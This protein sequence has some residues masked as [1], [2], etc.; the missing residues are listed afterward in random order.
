MLL[1][2]LLAPWAANAQQTAPYNEGFEAM[3][4]VTDLNTAGWEMLYK[5]HS[6][7]FL[8]IETGASNVFAGSKALNIDSWNAG[9]S[10]DWVIV[11]LPTISNKA[12]N[13]LQMTFSY[14]VSTGNV[15]IGYLTDPDD[16]STFVT[17][18]S[19]NSSSS[20]STKTVEFDGVPAT[21]TRIAIKY[22]NYYRCYVD[23][24]EVKQ[25]PN[26]KTPQNLTPSNL[27]ADRVTLTWERNAA[28]TE[29]AW[30][31]EYGTTSDF[32]GA[33]TVSVTGGNPTKT[34]TGLTENTKY[35]ARVKADCGGEES[36]P[37]AAISFTTLCEPTTIPTEGWS[38][39]FDSYTHTSNTT[40][41]NNL[42][43]CWSYI[44]TTTYSSYQGY[45][46]VYYG[47]SYSSSG[48]YHLRLYSYYS[49]WSDYDPQPQYAIL[50]PMDNLTGKQITLKA[51]GYNTSSTFKIGTMTDPSDPSTFVAI[52]EQTG[53]TTSYQEFTYPLSGTN[54][55]VVIMIDAANSSRSTNAVY[56]DDIVIN[57]A[58]NCVKPIG[59]DLE[60]TGQTATFTWTSDASQWQVAYSKDASADP[61]DNIVG[62]VDVK[63]F[64]KDNLELDTDHYF[65][66]RTYCGASE[67]SEWAGPASVHIGYCLPNPSSR[68]GKGIT[69]VIFG[70]S[71]YVVNNVDET[72]G[73]PASSPFYGNY[74][75]MVGSMQAGVEST[76]SI[77]YATGSSTVY[78]YGTIIWV[79]WDNS[80]S[81]E[82]SEIVYTGT[83]TQ[84]S[85]GVPQVLDATITIP[86]T[87]ATGEYR[88]RI[89]GADSYFD[90]YISGSSSVAPNPCFTS[91]YAVCHDY[92]LRVLEAPSCLTPTALDVT[93]TGATATAT[94]SGT[95][96]SYNIDINGTVTNNVNTPYE[97][98]LELSTDYT[99]KVQANCAGN[100]TSDWSNAFTFSTPDCWT[101]RIIE[102]S[103]TDSYGDGWNGASITVIEGCG[104]VFE[105]LTVTAA[106]NSGTLTL[107]GDY[108]Q[109]IWN[110][111]SYDSE[112]SFTFSEGGTTLFTKPSSVS[113]GLVLYTLGTQTCPT[114]SGLTA[115]VPDRD[116][117]EL[118]W[119]ENGTATAWQICINGDESNLVDADTNPFTLT[120]LTPDTDYAVKVRAFC[121]KTDQSCWSNEVNFTTAEACAK[122]TS[123]TETGITTTSA[124]M[125]WTGTS[126]SYVLQYRP[127][128]QVGQDSLSTDTYTTYT[129]DLS[130]YKGQGSIAI[131]HYDVSD[132]FYLNVDNVELRASDNT[133]IFSEG[134]ESGAIPS[135]WT[136]YDVDG[137]GY[138]WDLA[139]TGSMYVIG[140]YGVYSASWTSTTGALTPDN[141]LIIPNVPMG[142][143]FSFEARGQDP[144]YPDENFAV[145]VSLESDI[146][147]IPLTTNSYTADNLTPGTPY[148]WQV[149]SDCGMYVSN[150]V[151]SLFKTKDDLLIFATD[152][153]WNDLSNW[154]DTDGLPISA[155]PTISNK[156]RID[157]DAIIPKGVVATAG[158]TTIG[159]S[160]SITIED[161]GQL[162]HNSATLWVTMEKEITGYVAGNEQNKANWYFI[163]TPFSGS[164]QIETTGT[165]WSH[166]NNLADTTQNGA[167]D[168]Y[169]FDPTEGDEWINYKANP[170]HAVF[171]AGNNNGLVFKKGYLYAS[172]EDR[173]V[174]FTGTITKTIDNSM[175]EAYVY[176]SSSS[177]DFSDFSLVGNPFA[178]NTYI[179]YVDDSDNVLTADFYTMNAAGD[180]FS[181]SSSNVALP[182]LTGALIEISASGNVKFSTET[183]G[184]SKS[185]QF[186]MNLVQGNQTVDQARLR[187]GQSS[188]LKKMSLSDNTAKVYIPQEGKDYAVV[189]AGEQG[190]MPVNFKAAENGTYTL[191][192]TAQDV[193]FSYLH[194]IDNMTGNDV[195]LLSNP[196]YTFDA[197]NTD[198]ASRFKLV[199]AQGNSNTGDN[200]A[201]IS[202]GNLMI[203]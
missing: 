154:T 115:G 195:D 159:T 33:T 18:E 170:T 140:N 179:N 76:I 48:N 23:E 26:C 175:T 71:G 41:T 201:F 125:S 51:R 35:Y 40:T 59:L 98:D 197:Q 47:S 15:Y 168:L 160:G 22:L 114:P 185:G 88:M 1:M 8:A 29:D 72:N 25:L 200:F 109:F 108:Y 73:L 57:D 187:F 165:S 188:N 43:D 116:N 194:L 86:A 136:N 119:T 147:E 123:L 38:E 105:T 145:Y 75:S 89:A 2:T 103:L 174:S 44:N 110:S 162:K 92:T 171:T 178:C 155:L 60:A 95:A 46:Y 120:G 3:S 74:A 144:S 17:V 148:A 9:S 121:D 139:Q 99:V 102:Y 39:N 129:Y 190:E 70:T 66:V 30:I 157:A 94:W 7:S 69:K 81:F 152:G 45:P 107:C 183:P 202:N 67:Q 137:D 32:T 68:D 133:V 203:L 132:K 193:D 53:L 135:T 117:V 131:R 28:G 56:I 96:T 153:D 19:F 134:F 191:S 142:G 143:T 27:T 20:Y 5:S 113:D 34:L 176:N 130:G 192:F 164:T 62:L 141:W 182:P 78:S 101:G 85:G 97:F 84:G 4:D 63:S 189:N 13:E 54:V 31:L 11:G 156:V 24:V 126:G 104:N 158:K 12:V 42:P 186:D 36:D 16:Y 65:W 146:T 184:S 118:S 82:E 100:E 106:S 49:S 83:S 163:S 173:T 167:Y 180:G 21:A 6:G 52:T 169:G 199:F 166:V 64:T 196:S 128:F 122:P 10:S 91:S 151:T 111:G 172:E 124:T 90:N 112:C 79:D 198:Y 150:W 87:Q 61:D 37:T 181:L 149:K 127:W 80:L 93:R 138:T 77:T 50:P 161:G 177:Y 58:P 14:K 55:C